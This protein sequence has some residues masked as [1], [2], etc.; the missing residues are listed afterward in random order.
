MN[1]S[2]SDKRWSPVALFVGGIGLLAATTAFRCPGPEPRADTSLG[3]GGAGGG[4]GGDT[5]STMSTMSSMSSMS[6]SVMMTTST[7]V[8]SSSGS[9]CGSA[10]LSMDPMNCGACFHACGT[11]HTTAL[12]TCEAG[13]C[14]PLCQ[15]G[16]VDAVKPPP[17]VPDDGCETS[18][19]SKRVFLHSMPVSANLGGATGADG[20]CQM[21]GEL[22]FGAGT[23]WKAWISDSVAPPIPIRFTPSNG[24]YVLAVSGTLVAANF[25]ELVSGTIS[26]PID[27]ME[28]GMTFPG[29]KVWT[30]TDAVNA[31]PSANNCND[32]TFVGTGSFGDNG[33]SGLATQN[34]TQDGNGA[35]F[36]DDRRLYCFE[37]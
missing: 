6:G 10:D 17:S 26:H 3:G 8:S 30:G 21:V 22:T 12:P 25:G 4:A 27:E 20:R 5:S 7:D 32:W 37:Q 1:P 31:V 34:W 24:P 28:N 36:L 16:F 33:D 29:A 11:Q 35:C 19:A 13:Q 2:S 15:P 14:V 18:V 23:I 9:P